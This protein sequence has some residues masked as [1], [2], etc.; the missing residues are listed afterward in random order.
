MNLL[1]SVVNA[2]WKGD[3]IQKNNDHHD[4]DCESLCKFPRFSR[5]DNFADVTYADTREHTF[6]G[7][8]DPSRLS[9]PRFVANLHCLKQH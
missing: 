4:I 1:I 5:I 2:L 3:I 9:V 7:H 8:F 6:W